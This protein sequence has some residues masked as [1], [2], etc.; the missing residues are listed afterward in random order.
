MELISLSFKREEKMKVVV[1]I[2]IFATLL[3]E[4]F[5]GIPGK[6][7]TEGDEKIIRGKLQWIM[8]NTEK[9]KKNFLENFDKRDGTCGKKSQSDCPYENGKDWQ[10]GARK[11]SFLNF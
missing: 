1:L 2:L 10:P 4:N 5:A 8:K 6:K 11:V 7:W 3:K 9:A